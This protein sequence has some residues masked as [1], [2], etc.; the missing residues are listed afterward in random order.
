MATGENTL[1]PADR[2]Y[3]WR[4]PWT[5]PERSSGAWP[6]SL[7]P[8]SPSSRLRTGS[9]RSRLLQVAI[10]NDDVGGVVTGPNGPEAGVWV[11]AE[12][13]DLPTKY[14]K[15]VVTDDQ[16][17]Y[18]LPDLPTA[19]YNVWVRGYGLVDLPK[20][21]RGARPHDQSHRRR[22]RR[23]SS[24]AELYPADV[25]VR[26]DERSAGEEI[27]PARPTSQRHRTGAAASPDG[28]REVHRLPSAS[29]RN[30]PHDP[31]RVRRLQPKGGSLDAPCR[32]GPDRRVDDQR[33]SPCSSAATVRVLRRLDRSGRAG[34]MPKNKPPRP[35]G[36]ERNVVLTVWD[37]S[38]P[39]DVSPRPDLHR[40]ARRP[41]TPTDRSTASHE[42]STLDMPI[43]DPVTHMASVIHDAIRIGTPE[44]LGPPLHASTAPSP[45]PVG[46]LG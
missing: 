14:A 31:A 11:I 9:P 30:R 38:D 17:R 32:V 10:D 27:S 19:N 6:S 45:S 2:R 41:S 8:P 40:P 37:W 39:Q 5:G 3:R 23:R 13:T 42:Y 16:G 7:L 4:I 26:D 22:S 36:V 15:I 43:L 12:T 29:T 33:G 25:L 46:L 21:A 1:A 24:A 28:R 35:Q 18:L 44:S 20:V 34:E